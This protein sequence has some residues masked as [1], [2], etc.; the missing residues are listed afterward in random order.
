MHGFDTA[1]VT[2]QDLSSRQT[3]R[4]R[5]GDFRWPHVGTSR[6]HQRGLSHGHGHTMLRLLVA[7]AVGVAAL[8]FA[9]P[10]QAQEACGYELSLR[11]APV[12]SSQAPPPAGYSYAPQPAGAGSAPGD[13]RFLRGELV[14]RGEGCTVE[15]VPITLE[16]RQAGQPNF[17]PARSAATNARGEFFFTPRPTRTAAVRAVARPADDQTIVSPVL[18]LPVRVGVSVTYTRAPGCV[19]FATGSTFPSKP[20]HSVALQ[21]AGALDPSGRTAE[22]V[23]A[24]GSTDAQGRYRLRWAAP[25]GKHDLVMTVARSASN[26]AGRSLYVREDVLATRGG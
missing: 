17:A 1:T 20:G 16:A 7:L 3:R 12:A 11:E 15:S 24:A 5:G 4:T 26:T 18:A 19:L 2:A 13:G 21:V 10:V 8:G 9:P 23:K 14:A 22:E 6:G 25:C